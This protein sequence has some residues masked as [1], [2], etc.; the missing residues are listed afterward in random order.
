MIFII[1]SQESVTYNFK[2]NSTPSVITNIMGM[3]S[4]LG[5][6]THNG[7]ELVQG[8]IQ[9]ILKRINILPHGVLYYTL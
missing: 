8:R 7:S 2:E 9:E 4:T 6:S 1:I 5:I 3:I